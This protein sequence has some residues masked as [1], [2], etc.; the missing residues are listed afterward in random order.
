MSIPVTGASNTK[1]ANKRTGIGLKTVKEEANG[2]DDD[3]DDSLDEGSD[4]GINL[5]QDSVSS[6]DSNED[7]GEVKFS[8]SL[9]GTLDDA[10]R[11]GPD[12]ARTACQNLQISLDRY[13]TTTTSSP[14]SCP[15]CQLQFTEDSALETH[16]YG[17]SKTRG[18]CWA[19]IRRQQTQL[20]RTTLENEVMLQARQLVQLVAARSLSELLSWE[21]S[22]QD[23]PPSRNDKRKSGKKLPPRTSTPATSDVPTT[24]HTPTFDW[25]KIHGIIQNL[26]QTAIPV[27]SDSTD[28]SS[29]TKST[30]IETVDFT[31]LPGMETTTG[32]VTLPP[33]PL[34]KSV[35]Q[36]TTTRLYERYNHLGDLP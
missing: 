3:D 31:N 11:F 18:C 7:D 10:I 6:K 23:K 21:P 15:N 35:L 8:P 2:K 20:I 33:I 17:T 1:T 9:T 25:R 32:V 14:Y 29:A 5:E 28:T 12:R 26:V 36:S 4:R 16:Y 22:V 13:T 19:L 24:C 27:E 34:N 30:R